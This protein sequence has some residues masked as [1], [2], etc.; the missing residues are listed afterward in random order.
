MN[1]K[2]KKV[3]G[4]VHRGYNEKRNFLN[5]E[6]KD[7][8]YR[9]KRID[10]FKILDHIYFNFYN[11]TNPVYHNFHYGY[12]SCD[13]FHFFNGISLGKKSWITTFEHYL[14]RLIINKNLQMRGL[15]S[16]IGSSCKQIIAMS[17]CTKLIQ[18]NYL[19]NNYPNW[20]M[21]ILQKIKV[22]HPAQRKIISNYSDKQLD[23]AL[24]FTIVGALFFLKGGREILS[25]F[26]ELLSKKHDIKLNIVSSLECDNY[27]SFTTKEDVALAIKIINKYPMNIKHFKYLPN[28]KVIELFKESHIA[29]LPTYDDT[30][31]YTVLEAQACG[32]PVITTD[33]RS[34]PEINNDEIGFVIQ[35]PKN[36]I[37]SGLLTTSKDRKIFSS[38]LKEKLL[39]LI[40]NISTNH[41]MVKT[42]G[43]LALNNITENH[44][45]EKK[46][47]LLNQ[48]YLNAIRI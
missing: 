21:D 3:V 22:I 12:G 26:D 36:E 16:L 34:L 19:C 15:R 31:G 23:T 38:I 30:Y 10:P 45:P 43:L 1:I 14:P 17:E 5:L 28:H 33:I 13:L 39:E 29:L 8:T 18:Q 6:L 42:K 11:R 41:D 46:A 47:D 20:E 25:V 32:C 7:F 48:I 44:C 2:Q 37:R 4:H 40:K 9:S 24:T 27:A 35:V